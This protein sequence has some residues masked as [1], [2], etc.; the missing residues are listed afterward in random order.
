MLFRL[1]PVVLRN[2]C[3]VLLSEI[4]NRVIAMFTRC[5][6]IWAAFDATR[7]QANVCLD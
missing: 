1:S 5:P 4:T 3:D 7:V 2:M 6:S